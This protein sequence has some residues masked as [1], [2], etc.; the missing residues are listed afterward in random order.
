MAIA[1]TALVVF[2]F[3]AAGVSPA[4]V[5][6]PRG[7]N[8]LA[9]GIIALVAYR[10]WPTWEKTQVPEA[11]AA[12]LDSYRA[13]FQAVRDGYLRGDG[14]PA[15]ELDG[16]RLAA[17]IAR[18]RL[19]ASVARMR[20]EPGSDAGRIAA[21][22]RVLADSHRFIHA[23][24]SLEAGLLASRPVPAREA[25]RT[26]SNHVDVTLYYLAAGLRGAPISP[27]ALPDLREDYHEL[28]ASADSRAER[29]ALVNT[30][31]DR[32]VNSLNTLAGEIFPLIGG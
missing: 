9:G 30:E 6:L 23:V 29:H 3:A 26:F 8:T 1:V 27:A 2:L 14:S 20:A 19:E 18:S 22:D 4:A 13:Y 31:A 5:V 32:I 10:L 11:L 12:T 16:T 25:F 24:M 21:F 28:L 15:A 7:L 17:R